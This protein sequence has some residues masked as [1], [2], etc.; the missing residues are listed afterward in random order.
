MMTYFYLYQVQKRVWKITYFSPKQGQDLENWAA[1]HATEFPGL[2][3]G[4]KTPRLTACAFSQSSITS[5][6]KGDI[7]LQL[8][9]A[10]RRLNHLKKLKNW[11][12]F[13]EVKNVP[14]SKHNNQNTKQVSCCQ[15][16][17]MTAQQ[18]RDSE[19]TSRLCTRETR[20]SFPL[21][22]WL[23]NPRRLIN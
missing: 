1:H 17:Q 5:K 7:S 16:Q 14:A 13:F 10:V 4:F 6:R 11:R 2:P 8:S 21:N 22:N 20:L 3:P 15:T 12:E 23:F 18:I 19:D 9:R